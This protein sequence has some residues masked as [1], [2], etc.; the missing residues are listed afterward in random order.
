MQI[1]IKVGQ[2]EVNLGGWNLFLMAL[3]GFGLIAPGPAAQL[4]AGIEAR[5]RGAGSAVSSWF[6]DRRPHPAGGPPL[7]S[8]E[9]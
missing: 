3:A 5:L 4:L 7:P 2:S 8:D 6:F 1:K 9:T